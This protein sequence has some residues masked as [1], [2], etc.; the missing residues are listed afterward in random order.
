MFFLHQHT[1]QVS[2]CSTPSCMVDEPG[3]PRDSQQ[4]RLQMTDF[5][6]THTKDPFMWGRAEAG[7]KP[8]QV[9]WFLELKPQ[10]H[11]QRR[12]SAPRTQVHEQVPPLDRVKP[13]P[14]ICL[15]HL[16]MCRL[17]FST[18]SI[19]LRQ[20]RGVRLSQSS[21]HGHLQGCV[22]VVQPLHLRSL[23]LW[24]CSGT[25]IHSAMMSWEGF[26]PMQDR[27]GGRACWKSSVFHIPIE[28]L[29]KTLMLDSFCVFGVY[30]HRHQGTS[31][32]RVSWSHFSATTRRGF[33]FSS[34]NVLLCHQKHLLSLHYS[35]S[36]KSTPTTCPSE[37]EKT[38]RGLIWVYLF[39]SLKTS[40][41]TCKRHCDHPSSW[42][43]WTLAFIQTK[44]FAKHITL[45]SD[46]IYFTRRQRV[47][48]PAAV[49]QIRKTG[50]S[51]PH[52]IKFLS[53]QQALIK[54]IE[55]EES[56]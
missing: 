28:F 47:T 49:I 15:S 51:R 33:C 56:S 31:S 48:S 39:F 10:Q 1:W 34:T 25:S 35:Y 7:T 3:V 24:F 14:Q 16:P 2:S 36:M 37:Q 20:D 12:L 23:L 11:T 13:D 6:K 42:A 32:L 26:R 44:R 54:H 27:S 55:K 41:Q 21:C 18:S 43:L 22:Q 9:L 5:L 19:E 45:G 40:R 4:P 53:K 8:D 17:S 46:Q 52:Q 29:M 38:R 50:P 30:G